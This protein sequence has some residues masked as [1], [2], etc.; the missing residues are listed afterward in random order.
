[1]RLV[2][3]VVLVSV[4]FAF[5][6]IAGQTTQAS[7]DILITNARVMDGSGNPWL[8]ADV[9]IRGDRIA[10]IGRLAGATA[11]IVIDAKD[12]LVTP[13]FIDVHSHASGG[14]SNPALRDARQLLAQGV[15]L[16]VLN[17]DGGGPTDL[18]QQ[19]LQLEGDGIG[20]NAAL[21]IG[22]ASVRNA[23]MRRP[24]GAAA[25]PDAPGATA[26]RSARRDPTPDE[27]NAMRALV[28]QAVA[29]GAY[30]LSSGLFYS[31]GRFSKTEEVIALAREAGGV[32]TSHIRDEGTYDVGV[33][34]SVDEVIRIAE[35]AKVR[36]VVSHMKC[37]GPD[38]WG[39]SKTLI[40]HIEAARARGLEI[41]A[42]QY[43]YE[44]SSTGL[45][46][47]VMPGEGG[48]SAKE[49]MSGPES[50]Q[51]FLALVKENIR[52]R[53]GPRSIVIAS[54]RGAPQMAGKNLE[55][56]AKSR[57]VEPEQAAVDIVLGGGASIVSFN[58]SEDDIER[59]M[60]QP[61]TMGSSDGGLVAP[62]ASQP[63]P[64]NNGAFPRRIARYVRERQAVTLEHAIRTM[65]SLPAHVFGFTGRGEIR[66]GAYADLV[67]FDPAKVV[68][69]A[70]YQ[71]PHQMAEG[72]DWAIVNGKIA[73][74]E[75]EFTGVRA[76]R[77][78]RKN[79]P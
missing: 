78:L 58:M 8:R 76:G 24:A 45:S 43:P 5:E 38:S 19:G 11:P 74:R 4:L 7:F 56:I 68:D 46:A 66:E 32:Y 15:T 12:R 49:A 22:H 61:W 67:I 44:A 69:R 14:L 9:G 29:D 54:G 37:L 51:R 39:L 75:G 16:A 62:G 42:D 77:V 34:A 64:R 28:K 79:Q 31:P 59:I 60:R 73:R 18:K 57:G 30:G 52:R 47:A 50:R 35:E 55:E 21:V 1:M 70:T 23:A 3:L 65:T 72:I 25:D 33:V 71:S 2:V 13:G 27:I 40:E 17:P 48:E 10:A 26:D 41:F 6:Q 53:G 63:H 20:I 36:G